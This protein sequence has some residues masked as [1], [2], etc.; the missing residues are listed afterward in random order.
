MP[1]PDVFKSA[2]R[3]SQAAGPPPKTNRATRS[4]ANAN[5]FNASGF[6]HINQHTFV[7]I[8]RAAKAKADA[9]DRRANPLWNMHETNKS[10]IKGPTSK[11]TNLLE[12]HIK[13]PWNPASEHLYV[14]SG[15]ALTT[16]VITLLNK[17]LMTSISRLFSANPIVE[18]KWSIRKNLVIKCKESIHDDAKAALTSVLTALSDIPVTV[19]NRP[20]TTTLKFA[21]VPRQNED[22]SPASKY[23]LINDLEGHPGWKDITFIDGPKFLRPDTQEDSGIVIVTVEDKPDGSIGRAL[24]NTAVYFSGGLR[25]C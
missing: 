25:Q 5:P 17:A 21:A 22:G 14:T 19:L 1:L 16:A 20:L 6:P 3:T 18:V 9:T 4:G 13:V 23:D 10:L 7:D 15:K 2:I 24:M 12:M 8:A 11:G